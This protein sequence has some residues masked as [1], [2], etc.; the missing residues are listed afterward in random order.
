MPK[1]GRTSFPGPEY[2]VRQVFRAPVKFVFGWCTD[3]TSKDP[4]LEGQEYKRRIILRNS[5]KVI[6]E[7]L[8][9]DSD[10]WYWTRDTVDLFP[11]HRWHM[12]GVG[13]RREV[14]A[15]YVLSA[16]QDNRTQLEVRWRRRR[17]KLPFHR[18]AKSAAE[19][20]SQRNWRRFAKALE[21]DYRKSKA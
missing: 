2:R 8:W 13:N 6:F 15:D 4:A 14:V 12:E 18:L 21:K 16:L 19:R 9:E 7:N 1:S 3:Y 20:S 11:P 5:R 17:G 10:G